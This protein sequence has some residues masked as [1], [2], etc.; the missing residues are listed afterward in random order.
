MSKLQLKNDGRLIG[1]EAGYKPEVVKSDGRHHPTFSLVYG[2]RQ[3]G[4]GACDSRYWL[5][6]AT[7][8]SPGPIKASAFLNHWF[9]VSDVFSRISQM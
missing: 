5:S 4:L 6:Y 3:N 1:I 8:E 2:G 7:V 9:S